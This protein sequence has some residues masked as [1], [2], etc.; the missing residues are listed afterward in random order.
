LTI[1]F[2]DGLASV[3]SLALPELEGIGATATVFV[4]SSLVGETY[5]GCRVM[6]KSMLNQLVSA[7]WEIGSH[8]ATHKNLTELS[9]AAANAELESSKE[10]L[11]KVISG[12]VSSLAYPYG[13]FNRRIIA[14]TA[15]HY[16]CARTVSQYPPLKVNAL[17]PS[18]PYRLKAI[19]ICEH[20]FTLP[21]HIF[22]DLYTQVRNPRPRR[23]H[24]INRSKNALEARYVKKWVQHLRNDQ[25]LI[26]CFHDIAYRN[27]DYSI[28]IEQFR[29]IV[30][31]IDGPEIVNLRD[32]MHRQ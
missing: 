19:D 4:I 3:F 30:R 5:R 32:G 21:L 27:T 14:L 6:T 23:P 20:P 2:D 25:W 28:A 12:K 15:K 10:T 1:T 16:A 11:E 31:T 8:T 26:L 24:M 29:E 22:N 13:A 9:D 18:D 7:K 17:A